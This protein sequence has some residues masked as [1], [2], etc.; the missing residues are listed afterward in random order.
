MY[1]DC[2]R[3]LYKLDDSRWIQT[4]YISPF[5]PQS[6]PLLVPVLPFVIRFKG[7]YS[8]FLILLIFRYESVYFL[9]CWK[10]LTK[11]N[12]PL[13]NIFLNHSG[14]FTSLKK[15]E[16]FKIA[17]NPVKSWFQSI[18]FALIGC[19]I[20]IFTRSLWVFQLWPTD[21][22]VQQENTRLAW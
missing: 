1:F 7:T 22:S 14:L 3:H 15:L 8:C 5:W 10:E 11:P 4:L 18:K 20:D 13:H 21:L 16:A 2:L 17:L 9:V 19:L 12:Q 6:A